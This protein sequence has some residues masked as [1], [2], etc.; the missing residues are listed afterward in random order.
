MKP[1][2]VRTCPGEYDEK[3]IIHTAKHHGDVIVLENVLAE[4][5]SV[6]GDVLLPFSTV[7][8]IEA[9]CREIG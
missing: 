3:R 4:V 1:C 9:K 5:C 8:A 2:S 7:E 6:C